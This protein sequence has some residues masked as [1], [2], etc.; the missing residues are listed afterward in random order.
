MDDIEAVKQLLLK[1]AVIADRLDARSEQAVQEVEAG[2]KT[3]SQSA[4][5]LESGAG[6]FARQVLQAIGEQSQ[7]AITHGAGSAIATFEGRLQ[8]A[9]DNANRAADAMTDQRALLARSQRTL[10]A[11]AV[12]A[13]LVGSVLAVGGTW[14]WVDSSRDEVARHH[15]E[16]RLLSAINASDIVLCEDGRLCVNVDAQG[17]R[18][19]DRR[20]YQLVERRQAQR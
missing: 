7:H 20:Q 13:L 11:A 2:T 16:A 8:H 15:V 3:L 4:H 12:T 10:V 19:G 18:Q 5:R 6:D 1:L 14:R 9:A 17:K